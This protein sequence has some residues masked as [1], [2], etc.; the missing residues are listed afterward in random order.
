MSCTLLG[1]SC[2]ETRRYGMS[3]TSTL[4][5]PN[6]PCTMR[7]NRELPSP[8]KKVTPGMKTITLLRATCK[9]VFLT[10]RT[11]RWAVSVFFAHGKGLPWSFSLNAHPPVPH[12]AAHPHGVRSHH[13]QLFSLHGTS[14]GP[15]PGPALGLTPTT[16]VDPSPGLHTPVH[17][18]QT[19]APPLGKYQQVVLLRY[20]NDY[21]CS[22][23][24]RNVISVRGLYCAFG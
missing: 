11:W 20:H 14:A 3:S 6:K 21:I 18:P 9:R 23:L 22:A 16:D 2:C 4:V 17:S 15:A 8:K 5:T 1:G 24:D 12:P 7:L 10:L 19:A 13:P